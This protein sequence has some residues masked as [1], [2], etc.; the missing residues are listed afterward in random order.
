MS[1]VLDEV[2]EGFDPMPEL[3]SVMKASTTPVLLALDIGTSGVRAA[4]FDEGGVEVDGSTIRIN[5]RGSSLLDS[6]TISAGMLLNQVA[7]AIDEVLA[8]IYDPATRIELIA[9]SCFWHSLVGVDYEGEATTPVFAW[10]DLSASS[11]SRQLR[12]QFNEAE[13]HTRT[14][15]RFHPSF[16]PAKLVRLRD[17]EPVTFDKTHR[18]LS[19]SEYLTLKLF[20]ESSIS[21]SMASGTGLLNQRTC[22]WEVGLL[23]ALNVDIE[24]LP[25]I[26]AP[27]KTLNQLADEYMLRWPQLCEARLFPAIGDGAA[28]N[29]GAGCIS[30]ERIALM[31]G[32]SGAMRVV[33]EGAPPGAI[34]PELWCYRVDR[35]RVIVGGALSDG[36]NLYSWIRSTLLNEFDAQSIEEGVASLAPDSHGLT[37]LPFWSGERST[38]WHEH[39]TGTIHGMTSATQPI[40]ILRAAMEAVAYRFALIA[41]ALQLVAPE[42]SIV[43]SGYALNSSPVWVQILA[44]VLGRSI[45]LSQSD[46]ASTRG[47][48]LLALEAAGKIQTIDRPL[49]SVVT[50]TTIFEPDMNRHEIYGKGLARQQQLYEQLIPKP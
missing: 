31:V 17:E 43:A 12:S 5:S 39:A 33:Y 27:G 34:P 15:C 18:W 13:I 16:W 7:E 4:L 47:A 46:E 10:N 11:A 24:T 22:E 28:N 41:Q 44:D 50:K 14:G 45:Q 35:D 26:S 19:F 32:T 9:I 37:V 6:G 40:E 2:V 38:G 29:I 36:G 8:S 48:A 42:A 23:Q 49:G 20:G 25:K 21:V 1:N 30:K 3:L